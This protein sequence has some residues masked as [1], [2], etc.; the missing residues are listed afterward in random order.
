[1]IEF[2][3]FVIGKHCVV[4]SFIG[5]FASLMSHLIC[6]L[7]YKED[8]PNFFFNMLSVALCSYKMLETPNFG[9]QLLFCCHALLKTCK[10]L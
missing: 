2:G 3:S 7:G 10:Q 8:L 4:A 9:I 6:W 5:N 1:M